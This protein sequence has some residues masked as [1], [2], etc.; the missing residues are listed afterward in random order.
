[1]AFNKNQ[2]LLNR[3]APYGSPNLQQRARLATQRPKRRGAK[4]IWSNQF[5]PSLYIPDI[6]RV[7]PGNF[8]HQFADE[9]GENI[10][11]LELPWQQY[12]EHYH[13][14]L[15]KS[16]FCS[17]GPFRWIKGKSDP[18][19]GCDIFWEDWNIRQETGDDKPKRMSIRD[20]FAYTVVDLGQFHKV[21]DTDDQGNIKVNP[22]TKKPYFRWVKCTAPNC[23]PCVLGKEMKVGHT[24]PW[25]MGKRHFDALNAH[26]DVIGLGCMTCGS[27]QSINSLM[28]VCGNPE[29]GDLIID[30][31]TTTYAPDQLHELTTN[32]YVCRTCR[33]KT[34]PIEVYECASC[35]PAGQ[36]PRRATIF[37]VDIQVRR[38]QSEDD[39]GTQLIITG[40]SDPK[41]IDDAYKELAKSLKLNEM[42]GPTA[43]NLQ[44][45]LF[46]VTTLPRQAQEALQPQAPP[47]APSGDGQPFVP[48]GQE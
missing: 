20:M 12:V 18:C 5:Q 43:L 22:R 48:Y 28:W 21:E 2:Q 1:M 33:E 15:K 34:F 31:S 6:V 16:A 7:V 30:M 13:G 24:Q 4:L 23:E 47:P 9:E 29:C 36:E 40:T 8:L 3:V 38:K 25:P 17:A 26:A 44:S 37:D 11:E 46:N 42:Y 27:R 19:H 41:P 14:V 45:K 39:T 35:T 10:I 32:L